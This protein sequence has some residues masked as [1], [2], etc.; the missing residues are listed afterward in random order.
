MVDTAMIQRLFE[1][2]YT[3]KFTVNKINR[4]EM[5]VIVDSINEQ[6]CNYFFQQKPSGQRT[7]SLINKNMHGFS[8]QEDKEILIALDA[9]LREYPNV[10]SKTYSDHNSNFDEFMKNEM[11]KLCKALTEHSIFRNDDNAKRLRGLL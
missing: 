11:K 8:N 6:L 5:K 10:F 3:L 1:I 2:H 7:R 9:V 4:K